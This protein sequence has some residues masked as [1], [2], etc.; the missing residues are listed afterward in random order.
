MKNLTHLLP[1]LA[2]V[3]TNACAGQVQDDA[4]SNR[5]SD[6]SAA[7]AA[8]PARPD[9][10]DVTGTTQ[11][12]VVSDVTFG[13]HPN[14]WRKIG[15][16]LDG[17]ITSVDDSIS[18]KGT[19][20][21]EP[22]S[23]KTVL[24]DGDGG[25]DNNLAA[26]LFSTLRALKADVGDAMNDSIKKGGETLLLRLDGVTS[27]DNANVTGTV[28]VARHAEGA[29]PTFASGD[30]WSIVSSSLYEGVDLAHPRFVFP[31]GYMRGGTW[32][33]GPLQAAKI[34]LGL[35]VEG[36]R[37]EIPFERAQLSF[38]VGDGS[39]G[40]LAGVTTPAALWTGIEPGLRE[41][42]CPSKSYPVSLDIIH[43]EILQMVDLVLESDDLQDPSQ[44]CDAIS[45]GMGF[46]VRPVAAPEA[47]VAAA[48]PE[49]PVDCG[50]P[51]P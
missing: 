22:S 45:V 46:N 40:V 51:R 38:H 7:H 27:D 37:F 6:T 25:I 28:F 32:V 23:A 49:P 4:N 10:G 19:C 14:D 24:A 15:Y 21:R 29:A 3:A 50:P 17:R 30:R 20:R 34:P 11:W 8:P 33:S 36:R 47:I 1:L 9:R 41:Y 12:F 35:Y 42:A 26:R 43:Q 39:N 18:S 5:P 31:W 2:V 16:D 48:A 44:P 13:T